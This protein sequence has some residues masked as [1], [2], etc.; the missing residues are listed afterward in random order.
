MDEAIDAY[1]KA[2]A[3]VEDHIFYSNR[4]AAYLKKGD[5]KNA[6]ADANSCLELNPDFAKGYSRKGAAL[7]SL[8]DYDNAIAALEAGLA[9][10]PDN[11]DLAK[12]LT[13]VQ[14]AKVYTSE[15]QQQARQSKAAKRAS[16][17]MQGKAGAAENMSDFVLASKI[18]LEL[19]IIALQ[20]QLALI[21][22]LSAKTDHEKLVM[23][24]GLID[25]DHDGCVDARELADALRKRNSNL[26][27]ADSIERAIAFVAAFDN[28]HDA[29]LDLM[30]FKG[31]LDAILGEM[32]VT[33]HELA[34]FMILQILFSENGNDEVEELA[35]AMISDDINEAVLEKEEF[36][37]AL[38]DPRMQTLFG[39]FDIDGNGAVDFK[40]VA[41]GLFQLTDDMEDS[42]RTA[43][44]VL[45]MLDED[46]KRTLNFEE[47]AKLMLHVVTAAGNKFVDMADKMTL[48]MISTKAVS[49]EDI[50]NLMCGEALYH[51]VKDEQEE[52]RELLE[53]M[54]A[55]QYGRMQKLFDLWDSDNDGEIS[56]PELLTGMRKFNTSID[57]EESV[58]G[59]ALAMIGFDADRNQ[60]LNRV[61]FARALVNYAAATEVGVHNL[62]DF[63]VMATVL[64]DDSPEEQAYIRGISNQVNAEI[65]LVRDMLDDHGIE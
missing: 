59:A 28:N 65:K 24:F 29:K 27:F 7:H 5:A 14:T 46:D 56:F 2:I 21:N 50:S 19:E 60:S 48:A 1:T 20:A 43:V 64:E 54:D 18:S 31:F 11:A 62:V 55:L 30:E 42:A 16:V 17:S 15:N 34:E 10:F 52:H 61:E 39:L 41:V 35:V 26:A 25:K 51:L 23:L 4:S 63:M 9:K 38:T 36:F 33:F 22:A 6:L 12:E 47:F 37:D 44:T 49:K 13:R 32:G 53:T 45:L 3:L 8:K 57:M 58:S 40:E